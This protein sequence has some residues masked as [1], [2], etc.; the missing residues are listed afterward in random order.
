MKDPVNIA[1]LVQR[2]RQAQ[3]HWAALSLS[4]RSRYLTRATRRMLDKHDEALEHMREDTGKG[5]AEALMS[6]AL[7]PLDQLKQWKSI[8]KRHLGRRR[9]RANPLAFPGKRF[10]VELLP[11]GVVASITPWNYP[12][13][14]MFRPAF[15]ALLAGNA[16]IVKPSEH[17]P[18]SAAWFVEQLAAELPEGLVQIVQGGPD[19]G[20]ALLRSGI[21]AATF[22]GSIAT[23]REVARFCAEQLIP[24]SAEL[25]GNDAAIVL[26]DCDLPRTL[27]GITHWALHNAGQNCGAIERVYVEESIA[28]EF[29]RQLAAAFE[30]LQVGGDTGICP[31]AHD[32][33]LRLVE[34]HVA[35]AISRGAALVCGGERTA[36]ETTRGLGYRPTILDKCPADALAMRDETFGPIVAIAR[37]ADAEDALRMANESRYGLGGS[38]WTRD[39]ARGREL[40]ERMH[41][42]VANVNNHALTGAL[43][44]VP[45]T[46][47]KETGT[48]IANSPYALTTFA[49]P[50]TTLVDRSA[51]PDVFWA[52]FDRD[53]IELGRRI[54]DLQVGRLGGLLK[55]PLLAAKRAKTVRRFFTRGEAR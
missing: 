39:L 43:V 44:A 7:G 27:A 17:S 5:L 28:E 3:G 37:A 10:A 46:G 40:A 55:I 4:E 22:T 41:C 8:C 49:R 9:V 45:W 54:A 2:A 15:P 53:L 31:L 23:G 38:V 42:G 18:R 51:K 24:C 33:Q 12:L 30:E 36:A 26:A 21:D 32:S 47:T 14:T 13:A 48:G 11:R 1:N 29:V 16:W 25:G 20:R 52:P 35:D 19:E 34:E 50:R 6:E